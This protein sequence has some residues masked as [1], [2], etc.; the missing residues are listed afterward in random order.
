MKI[1]KEVNKSE[2]KAILKRVYEADTASGYVD[3]STVAGS[4][5]TAF[6]KN[7]EIT[8]QSN[9]Y[10]DSTLEELIDEAISKEN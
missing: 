4:V 6:Y 9:Y 10:Q 8:L 5:I 3:K 1:T 7:G 2:A